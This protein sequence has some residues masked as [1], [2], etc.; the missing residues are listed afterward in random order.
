MHFAKPT[1]SAEI[2]N[3]AGRYL[4]ETADSGGLSIH[5]GAEYELATTVVNNWRAAHM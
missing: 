5:S 4:A 2:V 1:F 3:R